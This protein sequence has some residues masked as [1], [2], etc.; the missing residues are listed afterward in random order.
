MDEGSDPRDI[1]VEG[2]A[3]GARPDGEAVATEDRPAAGSAE[4]V[5]RRL[6]REVEGLQDRLLRL[7]AEFDNYRKREAR[8]RAA[9]WGRAK[10]DL[11]TKLLGPLD[12]L[13][14]IAGLDPATGAAPA[15][16]EGAR[17]VERKLLDAFE[18]EGLAAVGEPGGPFDPPRPEAIGVQPTASAERDA[19][20]AAVL[21]P[22]YT[23]GSQLLR[24]AKIQVYEHR[25]EG[26][27]G[28]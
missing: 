28:D 9:A 17:L 13:R 7:Q 8:E 1:P 10:A 15:V 2:A 21:A 22:G 16:V 18:R 4:D 5:E 11:V 19:T 23:F 12:D 14:R 6:Q 24:P 20:V 3:P 26:A 25:P 27:G